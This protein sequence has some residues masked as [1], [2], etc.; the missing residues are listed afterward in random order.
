MAASPPD[1]IELRG[2]RVVAVHGLLEEETRRPQPFEVDLE[3][4]VDTAVAGISDDLADTV[5]YG[6]VLDTAASVVSGA[7]HRL[8]ESLAGAVADAVLTH[9]RVVAVTV[10]V[11][12]LR[13]P[14][15]HDVVS[16]GVRVTRTGP[17]SGA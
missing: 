9:P 7:P 11:R 14:V 2:L 15:P 3:L 8:L 12:K 1:R 17:A 4:D 5:D 16:V 13:P 6:A 10:T